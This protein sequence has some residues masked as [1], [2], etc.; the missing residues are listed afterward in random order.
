MK[1]RNCYWLMNHECSQEQR[2]EL[3]ERFGVSKIIYPDDFIRELWRSIPCDDSIHGRILDQWM[4]CILP[5]DIAVVQ[6]DS[7]YTFYV[8]DA[9]LRKG[10]IVLASATKRM[11]LH[12]TEAIDGSTITRQF[13][14]EIFRRYVRKI[15]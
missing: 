15:E 12:E 6:G 14:H 8:V 13:R 4:D 11:I 7:T 3:R 9:L 5:D 1:T 2:K 10:V